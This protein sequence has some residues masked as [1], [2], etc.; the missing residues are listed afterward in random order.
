MI[1][2]IFLLLTFFIYNMVI[3]HNTK[4]LPVKLLPI[5]GGAAPSP[6]GIHA[7]TINRDGLFFFDREAVSLD[8]LGAKLTELAADPEGPTLFLA[9]EKQGKVDRGPLFVQLIERVVE[10][11]ITDFAIVGPPSGDGEIGGAERGGRRGA[12]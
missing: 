6:K 12:P 5:A 3:M 1:D 4:V 8:A 7:I 11:G 2:V 9:V 10:A